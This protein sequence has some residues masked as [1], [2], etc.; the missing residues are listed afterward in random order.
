MQLQ[1]GFERVSRLVGRKRVEQFDRSFD[2]AS[3]LGDSSTAL[4]PLT[5]L[6]VARNRLV[7]VG[8]FVEV[9]RDR[10][11]FSLRRGGSML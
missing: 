9:A 11:G 4:R 2:E 10:N 1:V 6:K 7:G 5:R 8:C 3:S